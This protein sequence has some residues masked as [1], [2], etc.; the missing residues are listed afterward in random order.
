MKRLLILI[1]VLTLFLIPLVSADTP[2]FTP[3][4]ANNNQSNIVHVNWSYHQDDSPGTPFEIWLLAGLIG[5]GLVLLSL[6]A[7]TASGQAEVDALIAVMAQPFLLFTAITSFAV[8]RIT[9]YGVTSQVEVV[10]ASP[11]SQVHEYVLLEN[12]VLYHFDIIGICM[13]V[14]FIINFANIARIISLHHKLGAME[15]QRRIRGDE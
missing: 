11:A 13:L 7:R 3:V 6:R 2:N 15:E 10:G 8:D 1:A 4:M 12:H 5:I 14:A 9:S